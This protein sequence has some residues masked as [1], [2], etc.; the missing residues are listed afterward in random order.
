MKGG[1]IKCHFSDLGEDTC[2]FVTSLEEDG[3]SPL[4]LN[5][6]EKEEDAD[7]FKQLYETVIK[8]LRVLFL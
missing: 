8:S 3:F 5:S 1:L 4:K 6:N 2:F 7:S